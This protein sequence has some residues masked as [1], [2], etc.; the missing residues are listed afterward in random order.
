MDVVPALGPDNPYLIWLTVI[1]GVIV[2]GIGTL[3]F[4]YQRQWKALRNQKADLARLSLVANKTDN[5][6][7]VLTPDGAINWVNDGFTR[8]S[9]Y[10]LADSVDKAPAA[11][12]LGPLQSSKGVQQLR[13]GLNSRKAF[14]T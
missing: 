8:L 1:A 12:L 4:F 11:I 5:A 6:V 10:T 9:G 14:T 13:S 2:A 7:L 3:Y